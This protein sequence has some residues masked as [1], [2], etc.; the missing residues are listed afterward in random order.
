MLAGLDISEW[1][2]GESSLKFELEVNYEW[3]IKVI[4]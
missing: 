1:N 4:R 3:E 2:T